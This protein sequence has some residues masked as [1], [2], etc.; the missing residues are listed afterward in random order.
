MKVTRPSDW[1]EEGKQAYRNGI[2]F[3]D[4][5]Y[6]DEPDSRAFQLWSKGWI[7][8]SNKEHCISM[9]HL[10]NVYHGYSPAPE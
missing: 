2:E 5:I 9:E 6:S 8:E 7:M 3:F 1:I 10:E 4:N